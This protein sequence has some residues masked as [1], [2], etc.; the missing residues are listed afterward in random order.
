MA[1]ESCTVFCPF[2]YSTYLLLA[3]PVRGEATLPY[4]ALE[5]SDLH[6]VVVAAEMAM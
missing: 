1:G 2:R 5:V 3:H 6:A 4:V